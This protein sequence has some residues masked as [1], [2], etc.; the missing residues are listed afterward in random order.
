MG[1]RHGRLLVPVLGLC[2]LVGVA[3]YLMVFT[4]LGQIAAS[5]H[6]SGAFTG[7]IVIATI[8]TGTVSAALFPA[9]GSVIGQRRLMTGALA[10]LVVGSVVSAAAPGAAALLIGRIVAAPGFAASTLSI[11]IVR[12][13]V[14][15]ARLPRAFGVLAAFAGIAAG[16][17]FTLGGAVEQAARS[18]WHAVF[19]AIAVAAAATGALA[20]ATIPGGTIGSRRA[21]IPGALLLAG[22]LVTALLPITE[23]EAWG[24]ASWRVTG[25]FAVALVLLTAWL[26]TELRRTDPLV[27]PG[28]LAM[29]GV[30][31]GVLLFIVT[32]A[33]VSVINLTV[34]AFLETPVAAGYGAGASVL[35]AGLDMLPFAVAI[36]AAGSLAGRLDGRLPPRAIAAAAL[37]CEASA[38]ALLAVFHHGGG[39]VVLLVAVFGIGHGGALAVEYVLLTGAVPPAAA[40]GVTGAAGALGGI[41]GAVA[42]AVT[43]ALLAGRQ[44]RA[45]TATLPAPASYDHAWLFA[46]AVAAAGAMATAAGALMAGRRP[47]PGLKLDL[48]LVQS[49]EEG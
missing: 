41:S 23:G 9:L 7:W 44:V 10:C 39:Q 3:A 8:V 20:A 31:A 33:T 46:A 28:D 30:A 34:P 38:L 40:G 2:L 42:S 43:T 37:A 21:D 47:G 14:P 1:T 27:R 4:L 16:L 11:A 19:A 12:E 35:A 45:G 49:S 22:G 48:D 15:Q 13:R 32:G 5:L 36:T 25:L 29:P 18:D 26:A 17:G 24:W 6:A